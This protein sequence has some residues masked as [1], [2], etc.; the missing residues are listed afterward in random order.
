MGCDWDCLGCCYG[1]W[2]LDAALGRG[3]ISYYVSDALLDAEARLIPG[4][5]GKEH[6]IVWEGG[7]AV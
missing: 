2:L 1:L 7:D 5:K 4:K 3:Y 6:G